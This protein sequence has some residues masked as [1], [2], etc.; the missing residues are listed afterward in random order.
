MCE[1][2]DARRAVRGRENNAVRYDRIDDWFAG[3]THTNKAVALGLMSD[4]TISAMF[5]LNVGN[6]ITQ[7][8]TP[9]DIAEAVMDSYL[10][11]LEIE[12]NLP[13]RR[14]D[15]IEDNGEDYRLSDF[16]SEPE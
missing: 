5:G 4:V 6:G 1:R 13:S 11:A 2:C 8:S 12:P 10:S 3:L 15:S 14:E 7:R 9:L 16:L